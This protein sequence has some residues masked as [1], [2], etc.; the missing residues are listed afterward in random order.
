MVALAS[1]DLATIQMWFTFVVIGAAIVLFAVESIPLEI[2][3]FGAVSTLVLFFHAFPIAGPDG[4]NLLDMG[5]LLMGFASPVLFAILSLLIIGEGLFKT[6]A[7]ERPA[8]VIARLGRRGRVFAFASALVVAGI[9]S[10]FLNNTPVVVIFVPI[11]AAMAS[12]IGYSLDRVM[13][14]L[15]FICILGGMTTLIGSSSNL[16]VAALSKNAGMQSI[17]FF[18][19]TPL[20]LLLAAVGAF[21]VIFVLPRILPHSDPRLETPET[22]GG[23]LF[24]IEIKLTYG[25]PWIGQRAEAGMFPSLSDMTVRMVLRKGQ[26]ILRPFHDVTLHED[27]ILSIAATRKVLTDLL[28]SRAAIVAFEAAHESNE[29][30]PTLPVPGRESAEII[31]AIVAPGAQLVGLTLDQAQR[32]VGTLPIVVALQRRSRMLRRPLESVHLDAGD[33]LL[34][35]GTQQDLRKLRGST[36]LVLLEWSASAVPTTHHAWRANVIFAVTI[37]LAGF[38]ILPIA[39]AAMAGALAMLL[40]GCISPGQ[41]VVA[42]DRRIFLLVGAAFALA[43]ALQASGGAQLLAHTV[44]E[45]FAHQGPQVLLSALFLLTATLTNFLSNQATAALMTPVT[46]AA[47]LEAGYAPEPFVYGLIFALNCSFATP[48]AYQTN[49]IVMGPGQYRFRDFLIGGIPLILIIWVAYSLIAP[50]YFGL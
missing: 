46:V 50:K 2:S 13:M 24:I 25:H 3:S 18:D 33:V 14:P 20:G 29:R 6:G 16:I 35:L 45:T 26:T 34:L 42:I 22:T 5:T 1:V 47:A 49:L 43:Q 9:I 12:S 4:E 17:G 38:G 15:S 23:R 36:D 27:D 7:I 28:T 40:C 11:M 37:L 48:I 30:R 8:R 32:R 39:A 44:V 19:F 41:A 31:E 10:G 21:Y